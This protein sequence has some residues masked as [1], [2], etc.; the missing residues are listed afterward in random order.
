MLYRKNRGPVQTNRSF[1]Y[2][3][4][5]SMATKVLHI[6]MSQLNAQVDDLKHR[7]SS[8]TFMKVMWYTVKE[9]GAKV[10]T[11][12][13]PEIQKEYKAQSGRIGESFKRPQVTKGD[14]VN[15]IIP[16][17][18]PRG[19]I[20]KN[21]AYAA[22]RGRKIRG[23]RTNPMSGKTETFGTF[24]A[25]QGKVL[26]ERN[27]IL[28]I[29]KEATRRHFYIPSGKLNG[30]VFGINRGDNAQWTG[31]RRERKKETYTDSSGR[32]RT[33]RVGN[34]IEQGMRK[35]KGK[36]VHGVGISVPQM[37]DNRSAEGVQSE[38][39]GYASKRLEHHGTRAL[40]GK[41]R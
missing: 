24:A 40:D 14:G 15:V 28:P 27:S 36:L 12:S 22:K 38:V 32:V 1:A 31:V 26:T 37:P 41:L 34:P 30:H 39:L 2:P 29:G 9:T 4:V 17:K 5:K 11:L 19:T 3:E 10:K 21:G 33:R 6:D 35:R 16:V 18:G 23:V 8:E 25:P 20:G 13:K 7:L